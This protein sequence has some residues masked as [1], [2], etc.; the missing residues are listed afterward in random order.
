MHMAQ[1]IRRRSPS[2]HSQLSRSLQPPKMMKQSHSSMALSNS[3]LNPQSTSKL[4]FIQVKL[5]S[6]LQAK[7][8][9]N[10]LQKKNLYIEEISNL[11]H[12]QP[13]G[14]IFLTTGV[15]RSSSRINHSLTTVSFQLALG[16]LKLAPTKQSL[17]PRRQKE[18]I[19]VNWTALEISFTILRFLSLRNPARNFRERSRP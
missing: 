10:I 5:V 7:S 15:Y 6:S 17:H 4:S 13:M 11:W 8:F 2:G 16:R 3:F 1:L 14:E 12:V 18:W 9:M 19:F